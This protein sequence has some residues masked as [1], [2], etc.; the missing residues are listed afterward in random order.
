MQCRLTLLFT[1]LLVA[2]IGCAALIR[3]P[4]PEV[5]PR[6][7]P[8]D[9]GRDVLFSHDIH[10]D[11]CTKCHPGLDPDIDDPE[12][13]KDRSG[14]KV[15][16]K[17]ACFECHDRGMDCSFCHKTLRPNAR[18]PGHTRGFRRHH[19]LQARSKTA[20]CD[21]C[22]GR[23]SIGCQDCHTRMEPT[24]HGPRWKKSSH[25]RAATHDRDRCFVCHRSDSC[26][27][28]HSQPPEYHT[29]MFRQGD[30]RILARRKLRA[31]YVCHDKQRTCG[32]CH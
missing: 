19:G 26:A 23:G 24:S 1:G 28:C 27:R 13:V 30:H 18:P 11:D 22:H 6:F 10:E 16:S 17:A 4:G 20:R 14:L 15:P 29:A 7:I 31:C 9:P 21:W 2:L 8:H 12:E 5:V 32:Q 3:L 25:G